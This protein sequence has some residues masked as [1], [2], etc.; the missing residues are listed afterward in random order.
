MFNA[1]LGERCFP[2][3]GQSFSPLRFSTF[4]TIYSHSLQAAAA[5]VAE[6]DPWQASGTFHG[7]LERAIAAS[8]RQQESSPALTNK[9]QII[10]TIGDQPGALQSVLALF[11]TFRVNM[12]RIES[13]PSKGPMSSTYDF[14]VDF[15][16]KPGQQNVSLFVRSRLAA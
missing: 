12:T 11:S 7:K 1:T 5:V 15:D 8:S 13:R 2:A 9:S 6:S 14:V 4:F 3:N 10:F 16:G